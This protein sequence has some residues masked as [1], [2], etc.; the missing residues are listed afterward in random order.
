[1]GMAAWSWNPW[2]GCRKLSPG[3]QHCY[4]YRMD[5]RHGRDASQVRRLQDFDL[6]L[7]RRRD[8]SY[9]IPPGELVYTCFTSDFLLEDAD[10]WRPAAWEIIARRRDLRFLFIT[11]R[12]HRLADCL[13]PD[14]GTGY[15]HVEIC[16]TVEDAARAGERLPLFR[17]APVCR[18]SIICEPLLGPI[19]L[20]PWLGKWVSLVMAGGE[21]GPQARVCRYEWVLSLREQCREAGVP[22][23]FRQTGALFEKDG[24]R[25]HIP[26]GEQYDQARRAGIDLI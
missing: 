25:Y 4:V 20:R 7:R 3:C 5:A 12:I 21:S 26:R 22:F 18:R 11:K 1:M 8:G 13:P 15:P 9:K 10:P 19:D 24:R 14:W 2:H 23:R 17:Q 6:P 16:C